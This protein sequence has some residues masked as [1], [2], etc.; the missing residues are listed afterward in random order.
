[1]ITFEL[2]GQERR[3][4][5]TAFTP[6]IYSEE[7]LTEDKN[8]R[9]RGEDI[10]AAIVRVFEDYDSPYYIPP[11]TDLQ[12]LFWAFEKTAN[13]ALKSFPDWLDE[14]PDTVISLEDMNDEGSWVH[15]VIKQIEYS[16]FPHA[17]KSNMATEDGD[18]NADVAPGTGEQARD[19]V[20]VSMQ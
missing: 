8:G 2:D 12:R 16:F 18:E 4:D 20:G 15:A 10:N 13:R 1:M 19:T 6:F 14:L 17:S 11:I 9:L 7:F 3:I 5:C